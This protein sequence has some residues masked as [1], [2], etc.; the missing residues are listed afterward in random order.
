MAV[1]VA[2]AAV[3]VVMVVVA[4]ADIAVVSALGTRWLFLAVWE[5]LPS[6]IPL[7]RPPLSRGHLLLQAA[8]TA[9]KK[10]TKS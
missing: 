3:V 8:F 10:N 1:A 2:A 9:Q 4:V 6:G 5:G 7:F